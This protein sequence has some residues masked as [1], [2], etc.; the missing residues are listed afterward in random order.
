M[1]QKKEVE[2]LHENDLR[3]M[4]NSLDLLADFETGK[5]RCAVCGDSITNSNI[6]AIISISG[7][8]MFSCSKLECLRKFAES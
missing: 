5:F 3:S 8:I 6:G 7:K 2:A 4:L 1:L